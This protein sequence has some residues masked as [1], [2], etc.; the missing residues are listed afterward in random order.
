MSST[1]PSAYWPTPALIR[2]LSRAGWGPLGEGRKYQAVRSVLRALSDRL[3]D[4]SA[5]GAVTAYQ[6]SEST[7]GLSERWTRRCLIVLEELGIIEWTRGGIIAGAPAPSFIRIIKSALVELINGARPEA[8]ARAVERRRATYR[9]LAT[10]NQ[11]ATIFKPVKSSGSLHA[12]LSANLRP[13][14]GGVSNAAPRVQTDLHMSNEYREARR[15]AIKLQHLQE[16]AQQEQRA[17]AVKHEIAKTIKQ[18]GGDVAS[19]AIALLK[20]KFVS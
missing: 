5:Q 15:R 16:Q 8:D 1:T 7:G 4:G 3:P 10:L 20:R 19:A 17:N 11:R 6:I 12:E 18:T 13:P 2:S 14:Y 9:R